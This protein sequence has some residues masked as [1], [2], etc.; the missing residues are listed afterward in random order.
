MAIA[1]KFI[2][3]DDHPLYRTGISAL[4]RQELGFQCVGEAS[5]MQDA[6][7]VAAESVPDFAIIDISLRDQ[8]GLALVSAFKSMYPSLLMLVV[9]MHDETMYGERAIKAGARGYVMKH[10]PPGELIEAVRQILRGGIAVSENLK[11]GC[12]KV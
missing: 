7:S 11:R 4:V 2:V 1:R 5:S 10:Q 12:S 9:S 8:N 3:V 6:L